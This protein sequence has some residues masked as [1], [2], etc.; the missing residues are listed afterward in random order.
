MLPGD[1]ASS[2]SSSR[3][4]GSARGEKER[5]LSSSSR[6]A[7][8]RK[9]PLLNRS[10]VRLRPGT[11]I[12][13]EEELKAHAIERQKAKDQELRMQGA[14]DLKRIGGSYWQRMNQLN[15]EARTTRS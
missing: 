10:A 13:L 12:E 1:E 6:S 3:R 14:L 2:E 9:Q 15:Q 7:E 8:E 11:E 5:R 4:R